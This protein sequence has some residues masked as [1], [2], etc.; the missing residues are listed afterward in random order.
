[1]DSFYEK[2]RR[3][4]TAIFQKFSYLFIWKFQFEKFTQIIVQTYSETLT[5]KDH[6]RMSRNVTQ[7]LILL[8]HIPWAQFATF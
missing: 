7:L 1:M 5:H 2:K 8:G 3:F 6:I 4:L